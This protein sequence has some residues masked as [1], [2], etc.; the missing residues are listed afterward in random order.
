[1][2]KKYNYIQDFENIHI[3]NQEVYFIVKQ[4]V[5]TFELFL[6]IL[7]FLIFYKVWLNIKI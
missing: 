2:A 7:I 4:I 1:V 5:D 3:N 6:M